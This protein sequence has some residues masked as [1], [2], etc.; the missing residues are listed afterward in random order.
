MDK[1][2][3]NLDYT[4]KN[5]ESEFADI[6]TMLGNNLDKSEM[7]LEFINYARS[8]ERAE[9]AG[10]IPKSH[11]ITEGK[12]AYC[13]NRGAKL[14][15]RTIQKVIELLD[16]S[17]EFAN[18]SKEVDID[19][20]PI[21]AQTKFVIGYTLC[22]A[23]IDNIIS[24]VSYG[25]LPQKD[26][27]DEVRSII[28]K[29][30]ESKPKIIKK[31]DEHYSEM[32]DDAQIDPTV[33][34]W[35]KPLQSIIDTI[36]LMNS[37]VR[38]PR[39]PRKNKPDTSAVKAANKIK[40]KPS[41]DTL[42]I[43]S[44]IPENIIGSTGVVLFNTKNRRCELYI[45]TDN[46]KLSIKGSKIVNFDAT[47]SNGKTIRNPDEMLPHWLKAG[48][49]KR[50]EILKKDINGKEWEVNGKLNKNIIILK[51]VQS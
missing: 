36:R 41:D 35:I 2:I 38:K 26:I 49:S 1:Q 16:R 33:K 40:F 48:N 37:N 24:K 32:F 11:I 27:P 34:K 51:T 12:I 9:D 28:R 45:A 30:G 17:E 14:E 44:L 23:L 20:L 47:R 5:Y 43:K 4:N 29:Y 10:K 46:T 22:Y 15:P 25:K 3:V 31:L 19:D 7:Q 42:G 8:I 50:L 18:Q 39:K 21:T 6:M 13:L